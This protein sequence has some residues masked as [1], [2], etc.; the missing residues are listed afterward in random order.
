M[1]V[2]DFS[3]QTRLSIHH[4]LL[5]MMENMTRENWKKGGTTDYRKK[6]CGCL[7]EHLDLAAEDL[8]MPVDYVGTY[9]YPLE[10]FIKVDVFP[11]V[12]IEVNTFV[13]FNDAPDRTYDEVYDLLVRTMDINRH[14][15]MHKFHEVHQGKAKWDE[16]C[17]AVLNDILTD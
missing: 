5:K 15:M 17:D 10:R 2:I 8:G 9:S 14:E 13:D 11:L 3:M 12:G 6:R 4:H 1:T 16:A 7:L